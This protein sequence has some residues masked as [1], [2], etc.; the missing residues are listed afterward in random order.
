MKI[1]NGILALMFV[2]F[3]LVQFN[4][5]DP[6]IWILIYLNMVII[7][8]AAIFKKQHQIW[9]LISAIL[10][11]IYAC[12][13]IPGAMEWFRSPDKA[14]LFDEIAKMQNLYIEET[15]EF[16]GLLICLIVLGGYLLKGR[17]SKS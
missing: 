7:C 6:V 4:D 5:P 14:M 3:T 1:V 8:A 13:L 11:F 12:F 16:L 17:V 10:Y 2:A 9:L 15:R